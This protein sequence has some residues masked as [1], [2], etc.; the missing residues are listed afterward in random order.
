MAKKIRG[1]TSTLITEFNGT[2]PKNKW[3]KNNQLQ[4]SGYAKMF[5][6][7]SFI[8]ANSTMQH[9]PAQ[10]KNSTAITALKHTCL[11]TPLSGVLQV[12]LVPKSKSPKV[13][14]RE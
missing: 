1:L 13:N 4:A 8:S 10:T 14:F 2:W 6:H 9:K 11:M 5:T 3:P 7:G 12:R